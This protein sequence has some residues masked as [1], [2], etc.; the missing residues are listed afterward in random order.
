VIPDQEIKEANSSSQS[1]LLSPLRPWLDGDR[2]ATCFACVGDPREPRLWALPYRLED[3]AIDAKRLPKAIQAIIS[4]YRGARVS[5]V[6]EK[7][8]AEVLVRLGHAAARAG[9]MP[10]QVEAAAPVY[11]QLEA[12]LDQLSRLDE[13]RRADS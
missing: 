7:E 11:C 6:P 12:I 10:W 8:V 3:G 9:K 4:N 5:R 2:L 1:S 13:V